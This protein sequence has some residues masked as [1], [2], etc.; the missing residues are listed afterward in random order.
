MAIIGAGIFIL[1]SVT[2]L[3]VARNQPYDEE[4][5]P[6]LGYHQYEESVV[7]T[8]ETGLVLLPTPSPAYDQAGFKYTIRFNEW[9]WASISPPAILK[10]YQGGKLVGYTFAFPSGDML[11][12]ITLD[13]GSPIYVEII[14]NDGWMVFH[15]YTIEKVEVPFPLQQLL[16]S[17]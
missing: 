15:G 13:L 6:L 11:L 8:D 17:R 1:L 16:T 5:D 4:Y 14:N 2:G 3:A 12:D 7:V 9:G 10:V